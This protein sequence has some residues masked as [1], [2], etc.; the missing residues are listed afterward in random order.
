MCMSIDNPRQGHDKSYDLEIVRLTSVLNTNVTGGFSKIWNFL[1][2][3]H[4]DK[5]IISYQERRFGGMA[6]KAYE[7][8]MKMARIT[9]PSWVGVN[10]RTGETLHRL[11]FSTNR[12]KKRFGANYDPKLSTFDN[13][14]N[15]KFDRMWNCG[16]Y[17]W[18]YKP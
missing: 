3:E 4:S 8:V 17:V 14:I 12:L 1:M 18:S 16:Q 2:I 10:I 9:A 7:S 6:S 5:K 13:M 15:N 11:Q